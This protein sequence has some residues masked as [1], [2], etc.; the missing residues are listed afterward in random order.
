M[1]SYKG[2]IMTDWLELQ[3]QAIT[4]SR[5]LSNEF[6]RELAKKVEDLKRK[7]ANFQGFPEFGF[8]SQILPH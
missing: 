7:L 6:S 4:V 8:G 5:L 2:D 3:S 1:L